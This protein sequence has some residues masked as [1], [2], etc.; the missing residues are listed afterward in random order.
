MLALFRIFFI[1]PDTPF[2][3]GIVAKP[4][5][6]SGLSSGLRVALHKKTQWIV[7]SRG[8]EHKPGT[9]SSSDSFIKQYAETTD[10]DVHPNY[11]Q[12]LERSVD[13]LSK[14]LFLESWHSTI[15]PKCVNERKPFPRAYLPI[16][17]AFK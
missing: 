6:G 4:F 2:T 1:R 16:V 10:H 3:Y 12:I 17:K 8:P 5:R 14:H 13:N 11:V 9:R 7:P 15:N